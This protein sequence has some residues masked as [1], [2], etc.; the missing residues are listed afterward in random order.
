MAAANPCCLVRDQPGLG[1]VG[2]FE[3]ITAAFLCIGRPL[4]VQ[5]T[6]LLR[7]STAPLPTMDTWSYTAAKVD[8]DGEEVK[9]PTWACR[10]PLQPP[11]TSPLLRVAVFE[12][13]LQEGTI[14]HTF[15]DATLKQIVFNDVFNCTICLGFLVD[16]VLCTEELCRF[17]GCLH[18]V[19]KHY[20]KDNRCPTCRRQRTEPKVCEQIQPYLEEELR[21]RGIRFH[22]NVHPP[23]SHAGA[24]WCCHRSFDNIADFKMHLSQQCSF[25]ATRV[26]CKK[27]LRAMVSSGGD[28]GRDQPL[29]TMTGDM[30]EKMRYVLQEDALVVHAARAAAR[31]VGSMITRLRARSRS[32][33][34]SSR[35]SVEIDSSSDTD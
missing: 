31:D 2:V 8:L 30:R 5:A 10:R 16:P 7:G 29:Q 13:A 6:H 4:E 35:R 21:R 34:R 14:L 25:L 33:S 18:C 3:C 1:I 27:F 11:S 32:R 19:T 24:L 26:E 20:K 17:R 28:D 15:G 22:C 23:G 12:N 9:L